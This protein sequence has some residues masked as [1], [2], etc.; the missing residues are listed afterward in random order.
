MRISPVSDRGLIRLIPATYHKPPTLR[1]LVDTDDEL[2]VLAQQLNLL[3]H[4]FLDWRSGRA[5]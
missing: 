5:R 3:K 4:C 1:G 2:E